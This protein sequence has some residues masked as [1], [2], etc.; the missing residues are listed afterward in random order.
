VNK[1]SER[2]GNIKRKRNEKNPSCIASHT[3][4]RLFLAT[5]FFKSRVLAGFQT[6]IVSAS[7]QSRQRR[8]NC[9]DFLR[10]LFSG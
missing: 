3:A 1:N 5:Q 10:P 9:R 2:L 8:R 7:G 6:F 4:E